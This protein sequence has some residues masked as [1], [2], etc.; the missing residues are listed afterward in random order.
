MQR[1]KCRYMALAIALVAMVVVPVLAAQ[2]AG[3][4]V[5]A[6]ANHSDDS[7]PQGPQMRW[8]WLG[9]MC[10][11]VDEPL[12][13]QLNLP[14][15]QGLMVVSVVEE[16]PAAEAGIEKYD[17]L[18]K[19][20]GKPI[21]RIDDL[22]AA[23]E[24]AQDKKPVAL[25]VIHQGKRRQIKVTPA[26]RPQPVPLQAVA[27]GPESSLQEQWPE[28]LRRWMQLKRPNPNRLQFMWPG[29]ILPPGKKPSAPLPSNV[30]VTITKQGDQPAKIV[31][32]RGEKTWEVTEEE[33]DK[34]PADVRPHV[35]HIL[36]GLT[37]SPGQPFDLQFHMPGHWGPW[38]EMPSP[39]EMFQERPALQR[40]LER[41]EKRIE[42]LRKAI[43]SLREQ[44]GVKPP[45][46]TSE[47]EPAP[48][49]S[50]AT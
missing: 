49:Q 23:V 40:R 10:Q 13:A 28:P 44:H 3:P 33:L 22:I 2:A 19:V 31:V 50:Q 4:Q 46:E 14:D 8:Y 29:R 27:P 48:A 41:M 9:L 11:P 7:A 17:V 24:K 12:R 25:E 6:P 34:L 45:A 38:P 43:D 35:E 39:A 21:H 1:T 30:T 47:P 26:K 42:Q 18:T 20:D 5:K 36:G 15:D 37:A 32:K 16:S